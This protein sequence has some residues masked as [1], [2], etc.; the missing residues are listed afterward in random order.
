VVQKGAPTASGL[1]E[2]VTGKKTELP[3]PGVDDTDV[4]D[5]VEAA[6]TSPPATTTTSSTSTSA[7]TKSQD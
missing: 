3:P 7:T 2:T 1:Q 4:L 5:G 6:R